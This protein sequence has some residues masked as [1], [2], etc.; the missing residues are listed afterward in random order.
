MSL[1]EFNRNLKREYK[2]TFQNST[3]KK[4]FQLKWRYAFGLAIG[5]LFLLLLIDHLYVQIY[6]H[7]IESYNEQLKQKYYEKS[8]EST[9][10]LVKVTSLERSEERRV[11]K[12]C[13]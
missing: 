11:G 3:P 7:S 10:K 13:L 6:N 5:C 8:S 1:K 9:S 2:D 12:E 4:K